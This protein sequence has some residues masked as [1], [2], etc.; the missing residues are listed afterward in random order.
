MDFYV[1]V[2]KKKTNGEVFYVGKGSGKR[3]WSAFGRNSLWKRTADK[4]GWLVEIVQD[5]R[6]D[7]HFLHN[8]L[9]NSLVKSQLVCYNR[10]CLAI[11]AIHLSPSLS[12]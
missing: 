9:N 12:S 4:Y 6:K 11:K 10:V 8:N 3:A 1:Y 7:G 2:H 5:N